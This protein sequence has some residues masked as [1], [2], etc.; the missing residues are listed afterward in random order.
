MVGGSLRQRNLGAV[1][2]TSLLFSAAHY[3]GPQGDRLE[4]FS[5]VFRFVAGGFF[6]LLF[7]YRGFGIAAGTHALYDIFV[8][9]L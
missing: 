2:L 1:V 7:V 8:G 6:A 4:L 9:L 5:F 3:L